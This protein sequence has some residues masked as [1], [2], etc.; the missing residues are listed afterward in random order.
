MR[1][2]DREKKTLIRTYI[3]INMTKPRYQNFSD[4]QR[5]YEYRIQGLYTFSEVGLKPDSNIV[6]TPHSTSSSGLSANGLHTPVVCN[7]NTESYES[8]CLKQWKWKYFE[9]TE[10]CVFT[11]SNTAWR[12]ATRSTLAFLNMEAS[13]AATDAECV[14]LVPSLPKA[15]RSFS[16]FQKL[17]EK[18]KHV[19]PL[20]GCR[21]TI[22]NERK[23][24]LFMSYLP[25]FSS[26]RNPE[27]RE[28]K[29]RAPNAF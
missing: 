18:I 8:N 26:C 5:V 22:E 11:F 6:K 19:I 21:R 4:W 13:T 16:L 14:G 17:E 1:L 29:N 7:F 10:I 27:S 3:Y 20:F 28:W 15:S 2:S 23:T 24:Q 9:D 25:L 12:V